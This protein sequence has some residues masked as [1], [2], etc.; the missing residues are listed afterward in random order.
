MNKYDISGIQIKDQGLATYIN[1]T[2][3]LNL[4]TGGRF[5]NYLSGKRNVKIKKL[6]CRSCNSFYFF[7]FTYCKGICIIP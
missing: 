1:L 3:Y 6:S 5:S 7:L 4:D 2:S